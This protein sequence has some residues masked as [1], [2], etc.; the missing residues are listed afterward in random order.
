MAYQTRDKSTFGPHPGLMLDE[1]PF[2]QTPFVVH[3]LFF[4][5]QTVKVLKSK[6]VCRPMVHVRLPLRGGFF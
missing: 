1:S 2:Q 3:E 5:Q 6:D 4:P